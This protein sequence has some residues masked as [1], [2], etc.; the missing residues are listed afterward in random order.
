MWNH[1]TLHS[2]PKRY[3]GSKDENWHITI[4][5]ASW[6]IDCSQKIIVNISPVRE[7]PY[8]R[9][10]EAKANTD[11]TLTIWTRL[12]SVEWA[13]CCSF[14]CN[15]MNANMV[16]QIRCLH[17]VPVILKVDILDLSGKR[18]FWQRYLITLRAFFHNMPEEFGN[19]ALFGIRLLF[20]VHPLRRLIAKT[21]ALT[22]QSTLYVAIWTSL[23]TW[24]VYEFIDSSTWRVYELIVSIT[25]FSIVIGSP[26]AYLSPNR[27]A[28]TWVSDYRCPI[29]TFSNRTPVIGYPRD[30]HVNSNVFY[31]FQNL[32]SALRTFSLKRSS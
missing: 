4:Q 13:F 6:A 7:F 3:G 9:H 31:S 19:A 25:K 11:K 21:S 27:R 8:E 14:R 26:L 24:R 30:F 1:G 10:L 5:E 2:R 15:G 32:G 29:W 22:P 18:Y 17:E 28:I 23:E 16:P 12:Q 20:R